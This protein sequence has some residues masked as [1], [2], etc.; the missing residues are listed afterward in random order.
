MRILETVT[1][2]GIK[3]VI[4]SDPKAHLATVNVVVRAGA[5]HEPNKAFGIA[6]FLEHM[7]FAGTSKYTAKGINESVENMGGEMNAATN[8]ETTSYYI[9][10]MPERIRESITL[11]G[12]ILSYSNF[13]EEEL[14][15]ER[16]VI[17]QER[18]D[19]NDDPNQLLWNK[20]YCDIYGRDSRMAVD[21]IGSA[22]EIKGIK[23]QDLIKFIVANY[24]RQNT[25]VYLHGNLGSRWFFNELVKLINDSFRLPGNDIPSKYR[26]EHQL[27]VE[28]PLKKTYKSKF[29]SSYAV[30]CSRTRTPDDSLHSQLTHTILTE[31]IGGGFTSILY[32]RVRQDAGLVYSISSHSW[33]LNNDRFFNSVY[34]SGTKGNLD[35]ATEIVQ[36]THRA[37]EESIAYDA[38]ERAKKMIQTY[39][40]RRL[41]SYGSQSELL[42]ELAYK[43][44]VVTPHEIMRTLSKVECHDVRT[45]AAELASRP[46]HTVQLVQK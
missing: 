26:T 20:L 4:F 22:N 12:H 38:F 6:H 19:R 43:G 17:L 9:T 16:R 21:I 45:Q 13:P 25:T 33:D 32:E 24:S 15:K 41:S 39:F 40:A 5:L 29:E 44:C 1:Q 36:S 18:T 8:H 31:L 14:A 7:A 28:E 11:L 35:K 2:T 10:T 30:V 37:G 34:S 42:M 3:V 46:I 23:R 27:S